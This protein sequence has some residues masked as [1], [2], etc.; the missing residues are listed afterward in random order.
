MRILIRI[1]FY[2]ATIKMSKPGNEKIKY[3]N[4]RGDTYYVRQ[5]DGNR[6][7]RYVCSIKE[8]DNDLH[9]LPDGYEFSENPNGKAV[10]RKK[11]VSL[12]NKDEV[13][14]AES[15]CSTLVTIELTKVE[16]KKDHIII[17]SARL[18][19]FSQ[20]APWIN[21]DTAIETTH[22]IAFFESVLKFELFDKEQR[23]FIAKVMGLY[24]KGKIPCEKLTN[25]LQE[26]GEGIERNR[27]IALLDTTFFGGARDGF[28][29]TYDEIRGHNMFADEI[30][31]KKWGEIQHVQCVPKSN[32]I[33]IDGGLISNTS[34]GSRLARMIL[35]LKNCYCDFF[36]IQNNQPEMN[37]T[38]TML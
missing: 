12:I 14:L 18:P 22:K 26:Y 15:L 24:Y 1:F 5:V 38:W 7:T 20:L 30:L 33:I 21:K 37:E 13:Q 10:C 19:D 28:M 16:Q 34:N 3:K 6:G 2:G 27:V 23:N 25:A 11:L 4:C 35:D 31:I 8:S 36:R 32:S 29:I 9:Q 17:H